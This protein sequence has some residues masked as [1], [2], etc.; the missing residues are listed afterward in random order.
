MMPHAKIGFELLAVA[1]CGGHDVCHF[2]S[3]VWMHGTYP[4]MATHLFLRKTGERTPGEMRDR[5]RRNHLH[6]TVFV[7]HPNDLRRRFD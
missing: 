3:V 7:R 1:N 2:G 5:L 6:K 4:I